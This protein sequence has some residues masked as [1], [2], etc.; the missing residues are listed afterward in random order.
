MAR[1]LVDIFFGFLDPLPKKNSVRKTFVAKHEK[2][3]SCSKLHGMA[4]KWELLEL[5]QLYVKH[6]LTNMKKNRNC[7]ILHGMAR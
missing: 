4:G 2:N 7:L 5:S 3:Q 1:K 6:L